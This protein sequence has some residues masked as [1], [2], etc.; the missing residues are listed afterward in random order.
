MIF[1]DFLVG[2][3]FEIEHRRARGEEFSALAA[4]CAGAYSLAALHLA[5]EQSPE[6]SLAPTTSKPPRGNGVGRAGSLKQ[7]ALTQTTDHPKRS[8]SIAA[9][10]PYPTDLRASVSC[11]F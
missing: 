9:K 2:M 6:P 7:H 10:E 4:K 8:V 3:D 11:D 5:E 1:N